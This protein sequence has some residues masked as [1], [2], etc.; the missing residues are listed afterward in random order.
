MN[1]QD[2]MELLSLLADE[3]KL[4]VTVT[5]ALRGGLITGAS[6]TVGGLLAGPIGMA[7]G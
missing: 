5:G 6:A 2:V 1:L 7:A 4:K 3:E